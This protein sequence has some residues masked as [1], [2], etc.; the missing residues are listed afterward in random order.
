MKKTVLI[1]SSLL[2]TGAAA[3]EPFEPRYVP[4][5]YLAAPR[6][7]LTI[8]PRSS[9]LKALPGSP[10]ADFVPPRELLTTSPFQRIVLHHTAIPPLTEGASLNPLLGGVRENPELVEAFR[11][12]PPASPDDTVTMAC[13]RNMHLILKLHADVRKYGDLAYHFLVCP[14]GLVFEGAAGKNRV[15]RH[16]W[17]QN[18]GTAGISFMGQFSDIPKDIEAQ[19]GFDEPTPEALRSAAQLMAWL[20]HESKID[21]FDL[22][23]S[24]GE[25]E[26]YSSLADSPACQEKLRA[27]LLLPPEAF[28]TCQ[29]E[30]TTSCNLFLSNSWPNPERTSAEVEEI[31][32]QMSVRTPPNVTTHSFMGLHHFDPDKGLY[33]PYGTGCPGTLGKAENLGRL[34]DMA[35]QEFQRHYPEDLPSRTR[36]QRQ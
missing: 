29:T 26:N 21:L 31:V 19:G 18:R 15:A 20:A 34:I 28:A 35:K 24:A 6:G 22:S 9:W 13:V 16:T 11:N 5:G 23:R 10:L 3:G 30:M 1:L 2:S 17:H 12:V 25:Q 27:C 8:V 14:N 32:A 33:G 36:P 7:G 4:P